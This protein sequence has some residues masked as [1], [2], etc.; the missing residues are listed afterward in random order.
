MLS[1][2][3]FCLL[4]WVALV[5]GHLLTDD[6]KKPMKGEPGE[7]KKGQT[8]IK[9]RQHRSVSSQDNPECQNGFP[10]GV[11]YLGR[12]NVTSSGRTCQVWAAQEPHEHEYAEVGEHNHCRNPDGNNGGVWCYTTDPYVRWEWCPVPEC[13]TKMKVLDF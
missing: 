3:L 6:R 5:S 9:S 12:M 2:T 11:S 8:R 4:F 7:R 10:I 1:S 13:A